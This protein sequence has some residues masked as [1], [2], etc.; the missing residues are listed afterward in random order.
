MAGSQFSLVVTADSDRGRAELRLLDDAGAQLGFHEVDFHQ[1]RVSQQRALFDLRSH[2]H[3]YVKPDRK[4]QEASVAEVGVLLAEKILGPDIFVRL[5][6]PEGQRMLRIELP[7][8]TEEE[9]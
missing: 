9:N 7:G 6:E 3:M 4:S 5:W 2:L 1:I 8:A